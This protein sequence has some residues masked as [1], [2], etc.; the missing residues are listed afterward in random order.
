MDE[1]LARDAFD[2]AIQSY[3]QAFGTFF[4]ARLFGL[5]VSYGE[6]TCTVEMSVSDFMFN[7]QGSL[8][9]GVI[10]LVMDISMGHLLNRHVGP[11][12]TLDMNVQYVKAARAGKLTATGYF[13]R[14]GRQICFLRSELT[15][16]DGDIVASATSTW[17]VL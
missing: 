7:P 15:D 6:K 16:S 10:A 2:R 4:L 17:K 14:R 8:H 1:K 13:I 11:G 5:I 12:A 3:E 9:G